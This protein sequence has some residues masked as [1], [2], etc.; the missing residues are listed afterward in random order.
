ME[1]QTFDISYMLTFF[2]KFN[3]VIAYR[4]FHKPFYFQ[5]LK[6]STSPVRCWC[7]F[8]L[9]LE[10]FKMSVDATIEVM[11]PSCLHG[12]QYLMS[13]AIFTT[14]AENRNPMFEDLLFRD[15]ETQDCRRNHS[16]YI[17]NLRTSTLQMFLLLGSYP[18][19][20]GLH[21]ISIKFQYVY[22]IKP[23]LPSRCKTLSAQSYDKLGYINLCMV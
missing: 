2:V 22:N 19:A 13:S 11:L 9:Y 4:F 17:Q 21:Q 10:I 8:S 1:V 23:M 6:V 12:H 18:Y 5:I 16:R 20:Y 3:Q 7:H 14:M 15:V